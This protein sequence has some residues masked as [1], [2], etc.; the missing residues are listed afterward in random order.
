MRK[1]R[2]N[3]DNN[4]AKRAVAVAGV[5]ALS[6]AS[7]GGIAFAVTSVTQPSS[8]SSSHAATITASTSTQGGSSGNASPGANTGT[9]IRRALRI[10]TNAVHVEVVL[11]AKGGGFRTIDLDK[12]NIDT[13]SATSITITP[14]DG[15]APVTAAITSSTREPKGVTFTDGEKVVLVSSDGNALG[16]RPVRTAAGSSTGGSSGTTGASSASIS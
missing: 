1:F 10:L 4:V 2:I 12:G 16:I 7:V 15:A 3:L 14:L 9:R 8:G 13:V 11:P 6:A 5:A